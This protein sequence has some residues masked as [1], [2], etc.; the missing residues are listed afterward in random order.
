MRATGV[1][2]GVLI[3]AVIGIAVIAV[4]GLAVA[5]GYNYVARDLADGQIGYWSGLIIAAAVAVV[6]GVIR[7]D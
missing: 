2:L 7:N 4:L 1:I 5:A 6:A 3:A